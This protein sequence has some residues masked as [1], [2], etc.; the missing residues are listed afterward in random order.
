MGS[1]LFFRQSKIISKAGKE[2]SGAQLFTMSSAS[3]SF[4][5]DP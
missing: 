5:F 1:L 2:L 3:E 4:G